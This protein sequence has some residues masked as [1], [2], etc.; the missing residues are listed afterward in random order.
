MHTSTASRLVF[1][2]QVHHL[3]IAAGPT[4]A[5][6]PYAARFGGPASKVTSDPD[7]RTI[8]ITRRGQLHPFD[9]TRRSACITL[10]PGS[11]WDIE[12]QGDATHITADLTGVRLNSLSVTGA[13]ARSAFLLPETDRAVPVRIV[14]GVRSV[15][16]CRPAGTQVALRGR[17]G[18]TSLSLDG[19][20]TG[21]L[22]TCDW[23]STAADPG[24]S[25]PGYEITLGAGSNHLTIDQ[26]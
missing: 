12:V 17:H 6:R 9:F 8:T 21:T 20:W 14:G 10:A 24:S 7:G 3:T 18:F 2:P 15:R 11:E 1:N 5:G 4:P 13:L 25:A 26:K 22:A 23:H 19:E 16:F